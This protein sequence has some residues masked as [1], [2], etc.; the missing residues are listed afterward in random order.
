MLDYARRPHLNT[1]Q[2]LSTRTHSKSILW[3]RIR[4]NRSDHLTIY[5][6][7]NMK[8][9]YITRRVVWVCGMDDVYGS[10]M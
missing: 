4:E 2:S 8:N 3:Y 6:A 9:S 7:Q 10:G 1:T 5:E